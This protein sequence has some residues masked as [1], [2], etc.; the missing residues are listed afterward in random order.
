MLSPVNVLRQAMRGKGPITTTAMDLR[1]AHDAGQ[2]D[3]VEEKSTIQRV[4]TINTFLASAMD[5]G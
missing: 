1:P 5:Y 4:G 2:S 3:G